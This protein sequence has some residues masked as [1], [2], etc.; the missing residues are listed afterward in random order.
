M[1]NRKRKKQIH[2]FLSED[3]L[4][5]VDENSKYSGI[6]RSEYI[7]SLIKNGVVIH[8][9]MQGIKDIMYEL[10]KIGTNINQV[11]RKVN[12]NDIATYNEIQELKLQVEKMSELIM[13]KI[14]EV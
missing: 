14:M 6:T 3:E 10:N 2:I 12:E 5:I 8:Y 1:K 13:N 4:N 11:A 7:R 9:E